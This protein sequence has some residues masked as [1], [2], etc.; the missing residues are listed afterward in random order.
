MADETAMGEKEVFSFQRTKREQVRALVY[1]YKGN[2]Y[3]DLRVYWL[4][5]EAGEY[6]PSKK[7]AVVRVDQLPAL[8]QAVQA[9]R[10]VAQEG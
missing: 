7:G 6:K 10:Q 5:E 2:R 9:M 8:A 4:D 3:A 1:N